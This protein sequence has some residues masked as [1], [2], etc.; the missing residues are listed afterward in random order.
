[1]QA[2]LQ[3]YTQRC[4]EPD[5]RSNDHKR[6]LV[7][8]PPFLVVLRISSK[9]LQRVRNHINDCLKRLHS[10]F[11]LARKV[12][13]QGLAANSADRTAENSELCRLRALRP[14]PFGNAIEQPIA[15]RARCFWR[16]VAFSNPSSARGYD[17]SHLHTQTNQNLADGPFLVR[18]DLSRDHAEIFLFESIGYRGSAQISALST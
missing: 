11:R 17:E 1:M 3:V 8:E 10:A 18:N 5:R 4:A 15:N 14:H 7:H 12:E 6:I 2:E 13:N 9:N 16:Y